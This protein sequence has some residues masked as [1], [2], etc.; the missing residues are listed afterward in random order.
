MAGAIDVV[1]WTD[2][3]LNTSVTHT[4]LTLTE[5][6]TYYFSIK[7]IAND[8][9][10][11]IS[12]SNGQISDIAAPIL[13]ISLNKSFA[14]PG[15]DIII[16]VS[17]NE[18][19]QSA[20]AVTI[21]Q[22]GASASSLEMNPTVNS[23][24]WS[25]IYTV[26]TGADGQ[27]SVSVNGTDL[28]G[29]GTSKSTNFVVDSSPPS[30]VTV[31][32]GHKDLFEEG[33]DTD[34]THF[35]TMLCARWS[36]SSDPQS[37][38]KRYEYAIGT[39]PGNNDIVDWTDN[40]KE[41][42]VNHQN[43]PLIDKQ[44]YYFSVRVINEA[45][46]VS[47]VQ[48]SDGQTLDKTG[49][50]IIRYVWDGLIPTEDEDYVNPAST[51]LSANWPPSDDPESGIKRYE[52]AIGTTAGGTDIVD[53]TRNGLNFSVT[54][55]G[56]TLTDGTTYYF[57][58][59]AVNNAE[60]VSYP[61][62]SSDG[63]VD[64][65]DDTPP[66]DFT[67]FDGSAA[68]TDADYSSSSTSLAANWTESTDPESG[69]DRYE[70][71]IGTTAG[72]TD[73]ADWTDSGRKNDA[74]LNTAVIRYDLS[75]IHGQTYYFS[76]K[77]FNRAGLVSNI[78]MSD[79]QTVDTS[80]PTTIPFV[81]DG[82]ITAVDTDY[83]NSTSELSANWAE[84]TD[85]DSGIKKYEYAIGTVPGAFGT[86]IV[87]WTDNGLNTS[88]TH[89]GL[90]L[91]EGQK[92]YFNVRSV[93]N[94]GNVS[95]P[96]TSSD[97]ITVKTTTPYLIV[98]DGTNP[99][100]DI[101][102]VNSLTQLSANWNEIT[103]VL[104]YEYAIGT[105]PTTI[106]V[107][108][109]TNIGLNTSVT[110]TG[111]TL[112]E[113]QTYYFFI[114]AVLS[115]STV[116][117]SSSDGQTAV[118]YPIL[119]VN[120]HPSTVA[121][122]DNVNIT[123]GSSEPLQN[124]PSVTVQQNGQQ[125]A[126]P[127]NMEPTGNPNE[128]SG[129][130]LVI[131][132]YDG[133]TEG[134]AT[135]NITGT[136]LDNNTTQ[137]TVNFTVDSDIPLLTVNI[138]PYIV[139]PGERVSINVS[140]NEPLKNIPIVAIE[141]NGQEYPSFVPMQPTANPNEWAGTYSVASGYDGTASV[142]VTGFDLDNNLAKQT[143][144]FIVDSNIA[145]LSIDVTPSTV[146]PDNGVTITVSSN[147]L[148]QEIPDV[149]VKQ[150]GQ[151]SVENITMSTTS[152]PN[153]WKGIYTA[154]S[155]YDGYIDGQATVTV[156]GTDSNDNMIQRTTNFTIDSD[157][158]ALT[159]KA[160][161]S[162]ITYGNDLT[163]TVNSNEPLKSSPY[164]TIKQNGHSGVVFA[165]TQTGIPN[166][167][168]A[169]YT[170]IEGFDGPATITVRGFDLDNNLTQQTTGFT[171]YPTGTFDLTITATPS[172]VS[173]G[174]NVNITVTS[175]EPLQD[176]P[177]V[178]VRQN[179]E[180]TTSTVNMM[181]T[182][183]P[184][185]WSGVYSVVSDTDYYVDGDAVINVSAINTSNEMVQKNTSFTI[186]SNMTDLEVKLDHL[187]IMIGERL[188][189]NV[190]SNKPLQ[191]IPTVTIKQNGQNLS[192]I[193]LVPT[194]DLN[195]WIG[196]YHATPDSDIQIIGEA[197]I[198]VTAIDLGNNTLT[199]TASFTV[200]DTVV[201]ILTVSAV[202]SITSPGDKVNIT[203]ASSE[204]LESIPTVTVQQNGQTTASKL[205]ITPTAN[206]NQWSGIYIVTSD[207]DG[208]IEGEAV[209]NVTALNLQGNMARKTVYFNI[210]NDIVAPTADIE[211]YK[212]DESGQITGSPVQTLGSGHYRIQL[213]V[214]DA[215]GIV[216][217]PSLN[218]SINGET[219]NLELTYSNRNLW[220]VNI[221]I[222]PESPNGYAMF[223]FSAIDASGNVGT[224]INSGESF[225]IDT[226]ITNITGGTI[227]LADG[228]KVQTPPNLIDKDYYIVINKIDSIPDSPIPA[229]G[230]NIVPVNSS[231]REIKAYEVINGLITDNKITN[232]NQPIT[233]TIPYPD[234]DN[235]C[236]I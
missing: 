233:I 208:Y 67:V 131:S 17:S 113:G 119:Y 235:D 159:I 212:L 161:P 133:Y 152:N 225:T 222:S 104:R 128:W 198:N 167:W 185:E 7:A 37:G 153:E 97:G 143:T 166:Q 156:T 88:V 149:T 203:V 139:A 102:T 60:A 84:S 127:V 182:T 41:L 24:E 164:I 110:R 162:D 204:P 66:T 230:M 236:F 107:I 158:A 111:L 145:I 59:R 157:I 108:G 231:I 219:Y 19:L 16:T 101:D 115:D 207:Y 14:V 229:D 169:V 103:G 69:I 73:I 34:Y 12:N 80:R 189:I 56:L 6:Q 123:I 57:T 3:G 9:G 146:A 192:T 150:N 209:I 232:F 129:I 4:G 220:I 190:S 39:L 221:F 147:K 99:A 105:N 81:Y 29:L 86:D 100:Q 45:G 227:Q 53:W 178:N 70:Y 137:R 42:Y 175:S 130:Y 25:G 136:D 50:K 197:T 91:A 23:N 226:T 87:N 75:L 218:Y 55:T 30:G 106:N 2:N 176:V 151:E 193:N 64:I 223:N 36:A 61:Y 194:S 234:T 109:W 46:L 210:R 205:N 202:P 126:S 188:T 35:Y 93:N 142:N 114:R 141:Q 44:T 134:E 120:V 199:E 38:I 184:N 47:D 187:H 49:P 177:T 21:Q 40:G 22:N 117:L 163:V 95:Y 165:M 118:S 160:T 89:T 63:I 124:P 201:D 52:Y 11:S 51:Q 132:D 195:K 65:L 168:T 173:P 48:T 10:V 58:V 26:I 62:I 186:D 94:A 154:V 20:P 155:D 172:V 31:L 148:L 5:G 78:Q 98:Y 180:T 28:S 214:T 174:D 121:P 196:I 77:A 13:T 125:S 90:S 18:P 1:N 76:V 140:S 112:T 74:E 82:L 71:A 211:I 135:V 181:P 83:T 170:P 116:Y 144:E 213:K 215:G 206:P 92:Y 72:G 68:G 200:H 217:T 27:V 216:E 228:T 79:G 85:P 32:D 183:N 122:G 96:Y 191:N 171:V 179:G 224:I 138:K 33:E 43:L 15:D 54:H 8:G